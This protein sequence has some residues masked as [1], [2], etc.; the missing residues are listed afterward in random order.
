M[1]GVQTCALP[2]SAQAYIGSPGEATS[3]NVEF[4]TGTPYGAGGS[5]NV[6]VGYQAGKAEAASVNV[7]AVGFQAAT[8]ATSASQLTAI[9]SQAG[10][11]ITSGG[12]GATVVGYAA[13]QYAGSYLT[14]VGRAAGQ[15]NSGVNNTAPAS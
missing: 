5:N 7:T 8:A 13:G 12:T 14:A 3:Y 1:T 11:S 9:G 15:N 4:G 2:I 6:S 10:N